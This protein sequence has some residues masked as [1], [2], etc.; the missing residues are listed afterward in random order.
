MT[1][2][3]IVDAQRASAE[4]F[5]DAMLQAKSEE[6]AAIQK[7]LDITQKKRAHEAA[8][9]AEVERKNNLGQREKFLAERLDRLCRRDVASDR[10]RAMET[11]T[12]LLDNTRDDSTRIR[13]LQIAFSEL[14]MLRELDAILP[15][16]VEKVS[17]DLTSAKKELEAK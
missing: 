3:T 6:A 9:L 13:E 17:A 7:Q 12:R 1:T 15:G 10:A 16:I 8:A 5:G 4:E 2:A 11:V 14:A